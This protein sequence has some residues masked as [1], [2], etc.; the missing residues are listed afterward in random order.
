MKLLITLVALFVVTAPSV[1]DMYKWT[2]ESGK[3]HYS[4]SPPPGQKAKKLDLKINSISGPPVISAFSGTAA[5]ADRATA[6]KVKL[7]TATWCGYCKRAKAYLQARKTPFQDFDVEN[8]VQGRS[9]FKAL[10]GRGIPVI[11][12]GD[13]RMD[14]YSQEALD[15]MLKRAGL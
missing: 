1:A 9:E 6:A 13:Q 2:D 4:D 8:S 7:Y 12:V 14:G 11:L 10:G 3:I 5:S 15:A